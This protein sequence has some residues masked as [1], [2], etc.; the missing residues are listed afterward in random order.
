ML[1]Y[2]ESVQF[3]YSLGNEIKTTKLG[4]ERIQAVLKP[5]GTRSEPT[6]SCTSPEP[7]AKVPPAP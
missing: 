4:L 7:M 3:L 2:P 1:S 5:S 6:A